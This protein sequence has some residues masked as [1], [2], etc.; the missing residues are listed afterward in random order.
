MKG[1]RR[2]DSGYSGIFLVEPGMRFLRIMRACAE[3][4]FR[5]LSDKCSICTDPDQF[6]KVSQRASSWDSRLLTKEVSKLQTTFSDT[7]T[8]FKELFRIYAEAMCETQHIDVDVPPL[9]SF[10]SAF[11]KIFVR[12]ADVGNGKYFALFLEQ[13]EKVL[14]ETIRD[15]LHEFLSDTYVKRAPPQSSPEAHP[16]E[17][18]TEA[19]DD[20]SVTPED[21]VSNANNYHNA[22]HR[23]SHEKKRHCALSSVSISH[24][25]RLHQVPSSPAD[26]PVRPTTPPPETRT[27]SSSSRPSSR[28]PSVSQCTQSPLDT[29]SDAAPP[30]REISLS[31]QPHTASHPPPP[32]DC[33]SYATHVSAGSSV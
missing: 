7:S 13:Q 6:R 31:S 33:A 8:S 15:S 19:P 21:S 17:L 22:H 11:Y 32:S 25:S 12:Q 28:A 27:G 4:A 16:Y 26:H 30:T 5:E 29:P 24:K 10:L 9:E 3:N 20:D 23:T 2:D 14:M 1:A 18:P